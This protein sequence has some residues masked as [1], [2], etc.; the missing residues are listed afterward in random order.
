MT[1]AFHRRHAEAYGFANEPEPTQFVNLRLI[2]I[3]RV[4]RPRLRTLVEGDGSAARALKARRP[5][6]FQEAGGMINCATYDRAALLA[7]DVFE[8]PA[9]VE[10]MDTTTVVPPGARVTVDQYGSLLIEVGAG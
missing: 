9:I 5:V 7:S 8:G 4:E 3:G 1:E 2:G 6:Y 10:Q